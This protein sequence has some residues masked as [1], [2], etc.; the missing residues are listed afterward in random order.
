MNNLIIRPKGE[1][2]LILTIKN[3]FCLV[4]VTC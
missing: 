1:S 4:S 3:G 2:D